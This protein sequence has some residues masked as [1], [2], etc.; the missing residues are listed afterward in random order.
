M[1]KSQLAIN[2]GEKAAAGLP[3]RFHFG[4]EEQAAVDALFAQS[5]AT[6]NAICKS[7]VL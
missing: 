4:K 7:S 1:C 2:G 3:N 5:I 6:G